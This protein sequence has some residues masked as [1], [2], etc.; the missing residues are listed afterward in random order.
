MSIFPELQAEAPGVQGHLGHNVSLRSVWAIG[1][2]VS[3]KK[4]YPNIVTTPKFPYA[5]L[6]SF[7]PA[8]AS[9]PHFQLEWQQML[10]FLSLFI[11]LH[12]PK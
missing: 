10:C 1:N 11:G 4:T 8:Q 2:L 5:P 12:F 6:L 9:L 3:K 7:L